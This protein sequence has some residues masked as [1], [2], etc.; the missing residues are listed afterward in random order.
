MAPELW[1]T[2]VYS[3]RVRGNTYIRV[4]SSAVDRLRM[5]HV[6]RPCHYYDVIDLSY[7]V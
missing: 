3:S 1:Y 5:V 2:S 6:A 7:D 4:E